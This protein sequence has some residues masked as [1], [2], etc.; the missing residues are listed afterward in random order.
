M[1]LR[2][3]PSLQAAL[4]SWCKEAGID[5]SHALML[6]NVP[7]HTDVAAIEEIMEAVKVL[8]RV[9]VR[10]TRE[11]PT[12]RFLLVLCESKQAIDPT[13]LPPE[14]SPG[15]R[16]EPWTVIAVQ[17][18]E[19]VPDPASGGFTERLA[20]FLM[21]EGKSLNDVQ[22]LLTPRSSTDSSPESIIRA[23][24]EILEKTVK[25]PSDTNAYRRLRT[26]SAVV[27][28]PPGE[29]NMETWI[30]QARLMITECE[31]SGKE[32]RRRIVESLKGPAL[33]II[34]AVRFSNPEASA[35]Q[36]L[37]ALEST[38]GS[39]ESGEDLYFKFRLLR[40]STGETLSEF[41]R[42]IEKMLSKVVERDGLSPG[43]IDK[44]RIEQLIR[45]AV[46][47]DMMLLQLRL[48]ERKNHPPS[49]L[50]LLKEIREAEESEASRHR[51]SAKAKAIQ[52][53]EDE[54]ASTSVIQEIKAEIQELRTQICGGESKTV[55]TSSL[56]IKPKEKQIKQTDKTDSSEVQE[57]RKQVQ[58]LQQQLAIM[59]VSSTHHASQIPEPRPKPST[60]S[61]PLKGKTARTRDDYFC[62]RCGEDGHIA[63]KCQAPPNSDQVIQKLIRSLRQAK[64][65]KYETDDNHRKA[66]N[67]TYFSKKSQTAIYESSSLPKGLVGPA[68]TVDVKLNGHVC[69]ALLDTGSQVTIVFDS[70]FSRNLPDVPIHPLTGL[71][72]WGLS[73][74]SYPYKGYIVVD[75]TFP[76]AVTGVEE[77]LAIL[78]LVC[79]D[80]QGPPQ[81][82]V[83]IGTNASFFKRLAALSHGNEG[84]HVARALKIQTRHSAIR[85][86]QRRETERLPD[87]PEGKVRWIG[88]GDCVIPPRG[89]VH[90][91]CQMETDKPLRTE[92]FVVD[93]A[94]ADS[95]PAGTF[96][97]PVVLPS[98][99]VDGKNIQVLVH[100]ETSKDISIPAGTIVAHVYPTD[101]LVVPSRSSNSSKV[102]DPTLFDFSES[103]IPKAWELRL[104]QKL[105][106]R[107]DVFSTGEW[108]V[109][110]ACGV[111]HHI[112]LTDTKPFRERSRRIAPADIEDV[113]RHIKE[114]L[115][116]GII[117]ESRSPYAS[118][119]V[120]ARKKSGAIRMCIDYR[121][122]NA[123]TIPDQYTTPRIDDALDCLTGSKWFSVLDLRS[124][125][126][127]IAMG[128]E[129]KEKTAFI[130]PLGF[131]QFERMPQGITGAPATFQRLMEKAVGDM[132]LLQVI[133]YLDDIIVF[134]R[135]LEE[136]EERLLKVLDRLQECGLKV[137]IDKC[138]FCQSQV[139]Y[140]GHIVS[141][142]GVSPDPAKIE[143]VTRWKMPTDLKSLRSFLGFC[144]F[145]RRFIKDYSAIVRPLTELTKGYPPTSG[146]NRKAV[147]AKKYYKESEPFGERWDDNCTAAFSKII[148]SLTHAPVL[149][150]ADP[151]RPYVLH[152]DAS[153]SG[154]G[155][156][157][158]QE[159]P[160]GLRPVAYAS[161]KLSASEQR[162]PIHQLEFLALKWAVVDKFHDYLYGAQFVVKTDNNPLTYV[163]SS[164]KLNTT[165]HRWLAALATYNFSLQYKPGSHNIDADVLS[166]YPCESAGCTEWKEIPKSGVKAI[167]QLAGVSESESSSRLVDHLCAP[168]YT[169]LKKKVGGAT[170]T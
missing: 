47:S 105:S 121:T 132:H 5:E 13:R 145:Y 85:L 119:I 150:F 8:G 66:Q 144:G 129:D 50:S 80:P 56:V 141:A 24:G 37:E 64:S 108:D 109:G 167:C 140:V 9:R 31:C 143:A 169:G 154:L 67:Q 20:K 14:V 46:N 25:H 134:G 63:T 35:L 126:Y 27:P 113:R 102:I 117:K 72:I 112:R 21:E 3:D 111:E 81:V 124:G 162:Y 127:Q 138:Q 159:H 114:L 22:A 19:S 166:R 100:N 65:E 36:Y 74:S 120:I 101:T 93:T 142:A 12:S 90:V 1:A 148:Y 146:Q 99:A 104:R 52:Y 136:H 107:G 49:F 6:I 84:A 79:P 69:Q 164:A 125:Y 87:K 97:T 96:I 77:S 51:M 54:R 147:D 70:W 82:P 17:A 11:G 29:E 160:G 135:T 115:A 60:S 43:L 116:A 133:V 139:R 30:E 103:S 158:N 26:F 41:L 38:F 42:R 152:V 170:S 122:L 157:L 118:P 88:P 4:I 86:P 55:S 123:R 53:R 165:G 61:T 131:F 94:E 91:I 73:S 106:T 92:I 137:S 128:E 34:R 15:E 59:S 151:T 18:R 57:L 40:Q 161:R 48:R 45:G 78:A 28:T 89:E 110:L 68:S 44:V 83:I 168:Y 130:C 75:V 149:A 156:V 98:S 153:L 76:A 33:E 71:S 62:Y 23:V 7:A 10:D 39:S 163:L 16:K 32:K 155:A 95:L 58:H 2:N